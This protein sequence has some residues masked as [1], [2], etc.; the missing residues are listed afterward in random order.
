MED[1]FMTTVQSPIH[2][3]SW[4][5]IFMVV[6]VFY[7]LIFIGT[8]TFYFFI[9][10]V[11]CV[12]FVYYGL[13]TLVFIPSYTLF[14]PNGGRLIEENY[15]KEKERVWVCMTTI[16]ERARSPFFEKYCK[17]ILDSP[18]VYKLILL[19]PLQYKKF[20]CFKN[21]KNEMASWI[22]HHPQ[23]LILHPPDQGP[24]TK[25]LG[26]QM[27]PVSLSNKFSQKDLL[28][29]IDD[30]LLYHENLIDRMVNRWNLNNYNDDND[31]NDDNISSIKKIMGNIV[32]RNP[33]SPTRKEIQ[34]SAGYLTEFQWMIKDLPSIINEFKRNEQ[35]CWNVDD[36]ILSYC[37]LKEGY[38]MIESGIPISDLYVFDE[39]HPQWFELKNTHR[40]IDTAECLDRLL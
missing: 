21:W 15:E 39:Y 24:A 27:F 14:F 17:R 32:Y 40:E 29:I 19:I 28:M 1:L 9:L 33:Q 22:V 7:V 30:D 38:D 23:I 8:I 4:I 2:F 31:N 35:S 3:L 13:Y 12:L 20:G 6:I 18:Y 37:F 25:L 26:L 11:L 36:T 5:V 34:A 10:I 16:P